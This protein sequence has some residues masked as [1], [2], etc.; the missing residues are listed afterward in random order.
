[1]VT[2]LPALLI[3][4]AHVIGKVTFPTPRKSPGSG[5]VADSVLAAVR[6]LTNPTRKNMLGERDQRIFKPTYLFLLRQIRK[7]TSHAAWR[8]RF[9]IVFGEFCAQRFGSAGRLRTAFGEWRA[10]SAKA[11]RGLVA[12]QKLRDT[13]LSLLAKSARW[14][15]VIKLTQL[16]RPV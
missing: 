2:L 7:T 3:V 1:M 9:S 14:T 13:E 11:T 8:K 12:L 6:Q 10:V 16:S 15:S 4:G 5:A